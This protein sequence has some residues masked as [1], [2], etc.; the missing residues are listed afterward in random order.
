MTKSKAE[1]EAEI[2]RLRQQVEAQTLAAHNHQQRLAQ[3]LPTY[4]VSNSE[5]MVGIRNISS[6]TV[7]IKPQFPGDVEVTL[8]ADF[9][10]NDPKSVAIISYVLW[11]SLRTQKQVRMG[12]IMRD[13]TVL[14]ETDLRAPEDRPEDMPDEFYKNAVPDPVQWIEQR[15]EAQLRADIEAMTSEN[16]LRRIRGVIDQELR[17]LQR[18][19]P[20]FGTPEAAKRA[21]RELPARY[22]WLDELITMRLERSREP[23][24]G[25]IKA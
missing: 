7:G 6:M 11:R 17:R 10:E 9:G 22:A 14:G 25:P 12:W 18:T 16:S 8:H 5:L 21:V 20:D 15:D 13:D 4:R 1:L 24:P 2:A 19:Y 23:E 3:H